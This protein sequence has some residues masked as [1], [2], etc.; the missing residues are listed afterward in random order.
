ML[1]RMGRILRLR[2]RTLFHRSEAEAESRREWELHVEFLTREK[3]ELGMDQ[4]AARSEALREMGGRALQEEASRDARGVRF[5]HDLGDDLRFGIRLLRKAPAL[6]VV[7]LLSLGLG[8]GANTAIFTLIKR[9]YLDALAVPD[10]ERMM[11]ITRSNIA[12]GEGGSF[13]YPLYEQLAAIPGSPFHGLFCRSTGRG[14][15]VAGD[16]GPAES[17][18]WELV[19]GNYYQV[20]GVTPLVGRLLSPD[21]DRRP[22]THP[23]AV[24]SYN[25]W[26]RRFASNPAIVGRTVRVN[27]YPLT[28]IGVSRPG[29]DGV[30]Q[31]QSNDIMIPM[32]MHGEIMQSARSHRARG[33][34]F[35]A[36]AGRLKPGATPAQ[37]EAALAPVAK[38][39][40]EIDAADGSA[41]EYYRRVQLS[42]RL[43]VRPM[44][45]GWD[46]SPRQA[47]RSMLLLGIT[48][49]VLLAACMNLANLL[50]ART[51]SRRHE[52]AMRM[53]LGAGRARLVRQLL[54]ESLLLAVL[55]G[56][57]GLLL[58]VAAGPVLLTLFA[59]TGPQ[60]TQSTMPD[61]PILLFNFGVATLCGI[62]F[63]LAPAL[64]SIR[65]GSARTVAGGRLLGRK[66][67]L[68][69]QIALTLLLL[70]CAGLFAR[71]LANMR[72]TD[73]GFAPEHLVQLT[74]LAKNAGYSDAQV[75]AYLQRVTERLRGL[76]GV[77]SVT[78]S[79]QRVMANSS[80]GSG[81]RVEGVEIRDSDGSPS[82]DAVGPAYFSTLGISMLAGREFNERD[83]AEAPKVAI[84]NEAFAK[85]YF[86]NA[87]PIGRRIDEGGNTQ[88][89]P[90][91]TI[92]GVAKNG[93]YREVRDG[94]IRFWYA[95]FEQVDAGRGFVTVYA[96]AVGDPAAMLPTV[97][98]AVEQ[99]DPNVA[100]FGAKTVETQIA[101][102]QRFERVIALLA[103]FFGG[104]A[105]LLAAIGLYGV[106]SYMVNQRQRE[107]G[108]RLALGA[109]PVA[110]ARLVVSSIAAWTALGLLLAAPAIYYA[111][112]A[113]KS[114]LFGV[115]PLDPLALG[116][117]AL[118][119]TLVAVLS[120][121]LP[122]RRAARISPAI[123]LR[124]D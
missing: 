29:F 16:A 80:W 96:R 4:E 54:T 7:S 72:A 35:L 60:I 112:Q 28:V 121:L 108:V 5:W 69:A 40:F 78:F 98:K 20:F 23:V 12:M 1:A 24:L 8:I 107:I 68:S 43:H 64:H 37:A 117:A 30:S 71:T 22:G 110:A 56:A 79:I 11:V 113:V 10:P 83:T 33:R 119:L 19:S 26:R 94:T 6:A 48:G 114:V 57:L 93:K 58:A 47:S 122:A 62:L 46:R 13:N 39:F 111:S 2:W 53:A 65:A 109:T 97:R 89:P 82:R 42:N 81:I 34:S 61:A 32:A 84:V 124:A 70:S 17:I 55:G 105:A 75:P 59:G 9:S 50:L 31:G 63:G 99:I 73:L 77:R 88:A 45:T 27:T 95:P 15:L 66:M 90:R 104:L 92:V 123:A 118:A 21:D 76:P 74:P 116:G 86:G 52:M 3:I 38:A 103:M 120:A 67:L 14:T 41:P 100:L 36:V 106:L 91:Y 44:A 18:S 25:F 101:E 49:V 115:E 85:F 87:N 51:S 102:G